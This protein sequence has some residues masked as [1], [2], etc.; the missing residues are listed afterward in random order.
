VHTRLNRG[1][2]GRGNEA[3]REELAERESVKTLAVTGLPRGQ[4]A[5]RQPIRQPLGV[6][7]DTY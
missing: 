1:V 7:L 5:V 2:A 4:V 3:G 6:R